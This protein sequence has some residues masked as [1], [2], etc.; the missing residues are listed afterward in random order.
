MDHVW[1]IPS[2]PGADEK[3]SGEMKGNFSNPMPGP[4]H[5]VVPFNYDLAWN[6]AVISGI[7]VVNLGERTR[8]WARHMAVEGLRLHAAHQIVGLGGGVAAGPV[9]FSTPS[10]EHDDWVSIHPLM[11]TSAFP[12]TG[13]SLEVGAYG[14]VEWGSVDTSREAIK[15]AP[16]GPA[17]AR[18]TVAE[19]VELETRVF[20][21]VEPRVIAR[22]PMKIVDQTR[23]KFSGLVRE[24]DG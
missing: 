3:A 13:H 10:T 21:D 24:A 11:I 5:V 8:A 15:E 7:S 12:G 23:A 20:A 1:E 14:P 19:P 17:R 2:T 16:S 18:L 9:W 22:V 6:S 4:T